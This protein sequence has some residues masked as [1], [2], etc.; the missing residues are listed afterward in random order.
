MFAQLISQAQEAGVLHGTDL[1]EPLVT[2]CMVTN[3]RQITFMVYQLNTLNLMDDKGIWNRTWYSPIFDMYETKQGVPLLLYEE[4]VRGKKLAGFDNT[5]C[6][7]FLKF[8]GKE[9]V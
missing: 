1:K 7:Y 4:A 3:G 8:I 5:F 9:T 6:K 2:Q